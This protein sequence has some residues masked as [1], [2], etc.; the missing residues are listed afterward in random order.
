MSTSTEPRIRQLDRAEMD[1][2]LERN[3]VGRMAYERRGRVEIEPIHYV[4]A[5]GWLYLRTSHGEKYRSMAESF[6]SVV[7]VAFEVDEVEELFRWRSVVVH[8]SAYL[9]PHPGEG[10]DPAQWSGAVAQLRKLL[11][12]AL[13]GSDPMPARNLVF[14]IA[15]QEATGRECTPPDAAE[16]ADADA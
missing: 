6:F 15:V 10:G 12:E 13:T 16:R 14:R 1:A 4:Y 9:V 7:P 2:I 11:P 8:G 3:H 5:D